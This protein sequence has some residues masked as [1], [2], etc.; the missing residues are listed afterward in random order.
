MKKIII[1]IMFTL[2]LIMNVFIVLFWNPYTDKKDN[3][4]ESTVV[5]NDT[6]TLCKVDSIRLLE[7]LDNMQLKELDKVLSPL[8]TFEIELVKEEINTCNQEEIIKAFKKLKRRLPESEYK[9]VKEILSP[10]I[11]IEELDNI[12]KNK[13]V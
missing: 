9:R 7:E 3:D 12:L 5:F 1:F 6:R 4:T 11:D 2:T 8:S 13:Y 10:F